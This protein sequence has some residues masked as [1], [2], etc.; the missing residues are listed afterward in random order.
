MLVVKDINAARSVA[1][2]SR[3]SG[4]FS[5]QPVRVVVSTGCVAAFFANNAVEKW[6]RCRFWRQLGRC[7]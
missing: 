4:G 7:K 6:G 2:A 3:E 1:K 5:A